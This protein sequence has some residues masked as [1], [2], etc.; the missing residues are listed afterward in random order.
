MSKRRKF[1]EAF[2]REAVE[3]TRPADV[4]VAQVARGHCQVCTHDFRAL[5]R[6]GNRVR[7]CLDG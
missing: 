3:L 2:K 6:T 7:S 5:C 4:T 1:S